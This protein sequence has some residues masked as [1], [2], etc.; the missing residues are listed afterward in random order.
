[1]SG[2][3]ESDTSATRKPSVGNS[4]N[5]AGPAMVRSRPVARLTCATI[6]RRISSVGGEMMTNVTAA[7]AKARSPMPP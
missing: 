5:E 3:A 1:M 4:V 2:G 7:T 6:S